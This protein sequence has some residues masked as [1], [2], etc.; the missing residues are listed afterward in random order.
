MLL[1]V[2]FFGLK[3]KFI[4]LQNEYFEVMLRFSLFQEHL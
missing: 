4:S 1:N 3:I 2:C